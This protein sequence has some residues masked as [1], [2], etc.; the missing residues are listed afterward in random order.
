MEKSTGP[1][2]AAEQQQSPP[3]PT[4]VALIEHEKERY[5]DNSS[6]SVSTAQLEDGATP[7]PSLP[8]EDSQVPEEHDKLNKNTLLIVLSLCVSPPSFG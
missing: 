7:S 8:P 3:P 4:S 2:A 5:I 1:A 6:N